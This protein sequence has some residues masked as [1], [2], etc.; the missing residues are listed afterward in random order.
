MEDHLNRKQLLDYLFEEESAD[1]LN[2]Y[3]AHLDKCPKCRSKWLNLCQESRE[4]DELID[5]ATAAEFG[6]VVREIQKIPAIERGLARV[7]CSAKFTEAAHRTIT[8]IREG[9]I[10]VV[11]ALLDSGRH[12]AAL[13]ALQ[14]PPGVRFEPQLATAGIGSADEIDIA[15]VSSS[16]V[17]NNAGDALKT[18]ANISARDSRIVESAEAQVQSGGLSRKIVVVS[19]RRQVILTWPVESGVEAPTAAVL[20]PL[21]SPTCPLVAP[22]ERIEDEPMVVAQFDDVPEGLCDVVTLTV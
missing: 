4:V 21:A 14:V 3:L 2:R 18:L 5:S 16:L 12:I 17:H 19:G 6:R 22:F 13:A 15:Q 1:Q 8:E 10:L 7:A 11:R 9:L 20:V